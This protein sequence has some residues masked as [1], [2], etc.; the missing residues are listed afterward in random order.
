MNFEV[1]KVNNSISVKREFNA[2]ISV[3]WDA[4]T[5]PELLDKCL[6]PKP[7]QSKTK[8]M[9]F[10]EGGQRLYVMIGPAGEEHWGLTTYE[11]INPK[12]FYSGLDK[13][14]DKDGNLAIELPLSKRETRFIS[15]EKE[16]SIVEIK[17]TYH[18]LTQLETII[19]MGFKEGLTKA[20]D[21]L[22]EIFQTT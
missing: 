11:S 22:E 7:Y 1:N 4:F 19:R 5:I 16:K 8:L 10:V 18:D 2:E 13:F 9:K 17:T 3:V 15:I 12:R 20:L 6:A 14:C 21:Q